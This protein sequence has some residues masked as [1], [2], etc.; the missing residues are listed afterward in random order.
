MNKFIKVSLI[1]AGILMAVGIVFCSITAMAGGK[2]M[3]REIWNGHLRWMID[4]I[5]V[6]EDIG[7]PT[8][9]RTLTFSGEQLSVEIDN[10][11]VTEMELQ[12][13]AGS[14]SVCQKE[15]A[16]GRIDVEWS[17]RGRFEAYVK[18]GTLHIEGF[19]KNQ[20]FGSDINNNE[21]IIYIPKG[22]VFRQIN[23]EAGAGRIELRDIKADLLDAEI[24]AGEMI[25][26][27]A[28]VEE[29]NLEIGMGR[30]EGFDI[31]ANNVEISVGMG[32]SVYSGSI[33]GDLHA[34][35]D[36][37]NMV[38]T[39]EEKEMDHN[40][41][42]QCSAGNINL[43]GR[44]FTGLGAEKSM[45]NGVSSNFNIECNMGNIDIEFSE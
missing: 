19:K 34:E 22:A 17:G 43:N 5:D 38:F 25:L 30:F 29:L 13:G 44:T 27:E 21:A 3:I 28:S 41:Q 7:F 2:R 24:G 6:I 11:N 42:I 37:G 45:N 16:D 10:E 31:H 36:L 40:Y 32:E 1:T 23:V 9:L 39:L 20:L 33:S 4:D 35:C 12:L 15:E 26:G 8:R 14:F 18:N